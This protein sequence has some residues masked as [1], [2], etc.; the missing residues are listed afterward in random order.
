MKT[1]LLSILCLLTL[2]GCAVNAVAQQ[3]EAPKTGSIKGRVLGDDGQPMAN[4]PVT[5]IPIGRNLTRRQTAAPAQ[6]GGGGRA[7][8]A[9]QT[10]QVTQNIQ[11]L[12][13]SQ[14]I[15]DDEGN[16][17]FS[18]LPPANYAISAAAPGF[19]SPLP[20]DEEDTEGNRSNLYRLG[21]VA[22]ITLVKGGVITGKIVSANN[23]PL[24]GVTVNAVRIGNLKGEPDELSA[25]RGFGRGWRTDDQGIYRI[26][27][28][29]PGTYIVQAGQLG[30]AGRPGGGGPGNPLSP[31]NQDAPTYYPSSSRDAA[32][33][34]PVSA[35][36]EIAGIDIRYRAEKGRSVGG[37]VITAQTAKPAAS[38]PAP[39]NSA[40][41]EIRLYVT[42][43]DSLLATTFQ[44]ERAGSG[45]AFYNIPDGEYEITAR[46]PG[47]ANESDWVSERRPVSVRGA[48]VSGLQLSLMPLAL[49]SGKILIEKAA[50]CS[51]PRRSFIEEIFLTA[52]REESINSA[53]SN[54]RVLA[55]R[56]TVPMPNGDFTLRNL[57]AGRWRL[58]TQL[59]DENWYV[60]SIKSATPTAVAAPRRSQAATAAPIASLAQTGATLKNGGKLTG[61]LVTLA[62]GAAGLKGSLVVPANRKLQIHL[63][64]AEKENADDVLRYS[65]TNT[66]G[67]G[68]FQFKHIAPGRYFLLAKPAKEDSDKPAWDN[69]QRA[70]LRKEAETAGSTIELAACQRIND[71]KLSAKSP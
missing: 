24:T 6:T 62:E 55:P 45:F 26:Y 12:A 28:L 14:V 41:L 48:D 71:F 70:A 56:S 20:E 36:A 2:V 44:N 16:F 47:S 9:V 51:S 68:T 60:R 13:P 58:Q 61:V 10:V 22:N 39:A 8:R 32:I 19:V 1:K 52:Q 33:P 7:E 66:T 31:F 11:P 21:D 64:P 34:L 65:Q 23:E 49:L 53:A 3:P 5:A 29:N 57:E 27:G 18:N 67:E 37:K 17:E 63:I 30:Q 54:R 43:T 4:V 35:G 38:Q 15:T 59:P 25:A 42:G 40:T 69:T 46:R 50:V